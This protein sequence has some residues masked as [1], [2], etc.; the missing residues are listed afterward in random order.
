[1]T[2]ASIDHLLVEYFV[3]KYA[4]SIIG[5]GTVDTDYS[6]HAEKGIDHVFDPTGSFAQEGAFSPP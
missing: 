4:Q 3:K 6:P 2:E 1:M 5:G